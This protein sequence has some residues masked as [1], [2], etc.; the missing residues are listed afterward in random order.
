MMNG[1]NIGRILR[2]IVFLGIGLVVVADTIID[3]EQPSFDATA[4]YIIGGPLGQRLAQIVTTGMTGS[5]LE[6]RLP[7]AANS[8]LQLNVEIQGVNSEGKPNGTILTS[9]S[10]NPAD[11]PPFPPAPPTFRSFQFSTP[12]SFQVGDQFAIILSTADSTGGWMIFQ[13][14]LGNPYPGGDAYYMSI[15]PWATQWIP[16]GAGKYD[17]PFQTSVGE[18]YQH[19]EIDIKPGSATN[20]INAK[21]DGV[22]PVAILT[23]ADFQANTVDP[24]TV[25]FGAT[26]AEATPVQWALQDVDG[27]GDLDLIL[28]FRTQATY[29][30]Y[31]DIAAYLKGYTYSGLEIRGSD[32]ITTIK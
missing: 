27:D 11:F 29:I 16:I 24:N 19:V 18:S 3:Q 14:P 25:R 22:I 30:Q 2:L 31:G 10:F 20:P 12:C 8:V 5:L 6:V 23:T 1:S 17:L 26:G 32:S 15:E 9:Q 7:I 13:G 4:T 21:I 28:H